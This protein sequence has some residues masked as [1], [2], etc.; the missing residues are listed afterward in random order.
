MRK[1]LLKINHALVVEKKL[2]TIV[3]ALVAIKGTLFAS[4]TQFDNMYRG[5]NIAINENPGEEKI[6]CADVY[7]MAKNDPVTLNDVV[8]TFLNGRNVWVRDASASL[9]VYLNYPVS[10]G[11]EPWKT[12]DKLSGIV[13]VV[14]IYNGIY[15]VKLTSAQAD[16]V[17]DEAFE[18]PVPIELTSVT[19]DDQNKFVVIKNLIFEGE[20]VSGTQSNIDVKI[21]EDTI[22]L[23]NQFKD[24]YK[25]E[26]GT[27]HDITAV[28][29]LY[30]STPLLYFISATS[31][32]ITITSSVTPENSGSVTV[33]SNTLTAIP[34]YGYYFTKWSDGNTN[35]PRTI[36]LTQ[37]TSFTAVLAKNE[38]T[39]TTQANN[40]K[41]GTTNGT[42]KALYLD[43]I[44]ISATAN[45]GYHFVRWNDN[46]ESNPRSVVLRQDSTFV[47]TFA[48][49]TYSITKIANSTQ[50]SISGASQAEYL[51]NVELM[52]TP[53]YGYH[54]VQWSDGITTNPRSFVLTKDTT[55]TAEFAKN[56]YSI[57]TASS[58]P[59][60]GSTAGDGSALYLDELE[61][62]ATPNY[63]YHFDDWND[64][65]KENPRTITV[66]EN[67]TYKAIFAKNVYTISKGANSQ[68]GHIYG[69]AQVEY[70]DF[71]ELT[72]IPNYGYHFT[73]WSD[74]LKDNPRIA[75][76][77][78]D[79]TF[80]AEF[81]YD[82]VGTCGKDLALVW[83]YD[84]VKKVLTIGNAGSFDENM[85][86]GVEAPYEMTEL[87][88]GNNVTAIGKQAFANIKTLSKVTIGE[89][90]KKI[91]E[92][93]F[94]D[95]ENLTS[96]YN[97]R[98]TPTTIYTNT[99]DGVEKFECTLHV[100][101]S[102]LDMYKAAT[103]WSE[104]YYIEPIGAEGTTVST[105]QVTV[106]PTDNTATMTW[107]T[108]DNAAS[109]TIQITKDGVVF[110]RLIFNG[111]GQLTGI[112]FAPGK[113]GNRH[114]PQAKLTANGMQFTVT[115]LNSGTLY[116]YSVTVKDNSDQTINSYEGSFKTTGEAQ[117]ATSLD[118]ITNDQSPITNKIIKDNQLLILRG[119]RTYT[120]TGQE[121]K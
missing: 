31:K 52:A 91:G 81:A 7:K 103:G 23:R 64:G 54:F 82:R 26:A 76:I 79:T 39:I 29:S 57:A 27:K 60:W 42:I 53:K 99:F 13:G 32:R 30:K 21:G 48:K 119:D 72:A 16:A 112:A 62:S 85:Q 95:C 118:Q 108:A 61:I 37:D 87:V 90:V 1:L 78:C 121:I 116:A 93:A 19:A 2:F 40:P 25:F 8:V 104:F 74:G 70:L 11:H 49:N 89:N 73:Q 88:V 14:D 10:A 77:T 109:Y 75:Q 66:N 15:E 20:F 58:N 35:N 100:L 107:P 59:A 94:Y 92:Q 67:K 83:S 24:G 105:N 63:G 41:W 117:V 18:A 50:G 98:S 84:P 80:T 111:N 36:E 9:L 56:T 69:N 46:N 45:Y 34:D 51:D 113:N 65:N 120:V 38:Y 102:S 115:G 22:V 55:F 5:I 44:Q 12:G 6:T 68:Q 17:V 101:A 97:Y 4:N 33:N 96:I 43:V 114:A 110:C 3:F 28:V 86:Y 106:E 71:A 47:A